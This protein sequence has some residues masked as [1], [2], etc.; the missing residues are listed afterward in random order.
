M[1]RF[2]ALKRWTWS[3]FIVFT[4]AFAFAG[5][6]GD[7]GATGPQGPPGPAGPPGPEGPPGSDVPPVAQV[8]LEGCGVCHSE[9]AFVSATVVH[10][11]VTEADE[12]DTGAFANFTVAPDATVPADLVISFS[13]TADG[14]AAT[15]ALFGRAYV[16]DGVTRTSLTDR[17]TG[18]PGDPDA[19]PPV[20]P[21]PISAFFTNLD[22]GDYSLL[23]EGGEIG[24]AHV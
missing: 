15:D 24:R 16:F 19:V 22:N 6:E 14:V 17:V 21:T 8:P 10:A 2:D 5:C 12:V 18:D 4:L 20:P 23:I 1:N 3:V 11:K 13:V 9:A 7:D